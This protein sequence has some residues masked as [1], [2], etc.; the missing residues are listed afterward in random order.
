MANPGEAVIPPESTSNPLFGSPIPLNPCRFWPKPVTW[1]QA[2]DGVTIENEKYRAHLSPWTGALGRIELKSG[3]SFTTLLDDER[4]QLQTADGLFN[5]SNLGGTRFVIPEVTNSLGNRLYP[6]AHYLKVITESP[7]NGTHLWVRR[8][9]EFTQGEHM[10]VHFEIYSDQNE[11]LRSWDWWFHTPAGS[12]LIFSPLNQTISFT[13]PAFDPANRT[14][15]EHPVNSLKTNY[16]GYEVQVTDTPTASNTWV[17]RSSQR[18][19]LRPHQR[20]VGGVALSAVPSGGQ[21]LP[22]FVAYPQ[23]AYPFYAEYGLLDFGN[24]IETVTDSSCRFGFNLPAG[25]PSGVSERF[26]DFADF[27]SYQQLDQYV[28]VQHFGGQQAALAGR[29][30]G[31]LD[32]LLRANMHLLERMAHE[33]GWPQRAGWDRYACGFHYTPISRGFSSAVYLWAYL[34][35]GWDGQRWVSCTNTTDPMY[36]QLQFTDQFFEPGSPSTF[37]DQLRLLNSEDYIAYSSGYR[38]ND[39]NVPAAEKIRGV[40]NAHA[41]ALHFVAMM[42]DAARLKGETAVSNA[43]HSRLARFHS[44]SKAMFARLHPGTEY[45]NPSI[46]YPGLMNY[47]FQIDPAKEYI[48]YTG[49]Y[50]QITYRGIMPGYLDAGEYELELIEA[51]ERMRYDL[52]LDDGIVKGYAEHNIMWPLTRANP[53][54]LSFL[55]EPTTSAPDIAIWNSRAH[56]LRADHLEAAVKLDEVIQSGY[57]VLGGIHDRALYIHAGLG[58][59]VLTNARF[60]SDWVPGSW[61]EIAYAAVPADRRFTVEVPEIPFDGSFGFWTAMQKDQRIELMSSAA[62]L[63]RPRITVDAMYG[64]ARVRVRRHRPISSD[65][66]QYGTWDDPVQD[67]VVH[68][69]CQRSGDRCTFQLPSSFMLG[70]KDLLIVELQRRPAIPANLRTSGPAFSDAFTVLWD[71]VIPLAAAG[72]LRYELQTSRDPGFTAPTTFNTGSATLRGFTGQPGGTHYYRVRACMT[73]CG[74]F[75]PVISRA[76]QVQPTAPTVLRAGA[77]GGA[78]TYAL[79]WEGATGYC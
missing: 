69:A 40:I 26:F 42:R 43:W 57:Q 5:E 35:L 52:D 59:Y 7:V 50:S 70:R 75:S 30:R 73:V 11:E 72:T 46:R 37:S 14:A 27:S 49:A 31:A 18:V 8:V 28:P 6:N 65:Y 2:A 10:Y 29:T 1:Q 63:C 4:F 25:R 64:G 15:A 77:S 61:E 67:V 16:R 33:G 48:H 54:S 60:L 55:R 53:L 20:I 44:G 58:R 34:T 9:Y 32:Q 23:Q 47:A 71:P 3:A 51:V 24:T 66:P 19:N 21:N 12:S 13:Y 76:V 62:T 68:L 56:G 17:R 41:H 78:S 79:S 74:D 39:P 38:E 22:N 45:E 36:E